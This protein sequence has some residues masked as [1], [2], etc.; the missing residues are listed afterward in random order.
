MQQQGEAG[1]SRAGYSSVN[2]RERG[3]RVL[4]FVEGSN[5]RAD[6]RLKRRR[7]VRGVIEVVRERESVGSRQRGKARAGRFRK[8]CGDFAERALKPTM[9][10]DRAKRF[11]TR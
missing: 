11:F 1:N 5:D 4:G 6:E 2:S 7:L 9:L 8:L 10:P 3:A